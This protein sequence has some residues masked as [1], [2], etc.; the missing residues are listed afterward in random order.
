[1]NSLPR[2]A[3]AIS[4]CALMG[5]ALPASAA[6]ITWNNPAG[7]SWDDPA[8]WS[9]QQ[10]PV[11]GDVA[12]IGGATAYTIDVTGNQ[13]VDD[14]D[15][16]NPNATLRI[17]GNGTLGSATLTLND[18][19]TNPGTIE[20]TSVDAGYDAWLNFNGGNLINAPGGT[21]RSLEGAGGNRY[22]YC[23]LDNRGAL[24][25][26][27]ELVLYDGLSGTHV[28]SG[29]VTI[30]VGTRLWI[31]GG[32]WRET[33][34][35]SLSLAANALLELS[36]DFT[37][38]GGAITGSGTLKL[39]SVLNLDSDL[40]V[41]TFALDAASLT[42]NGP[43]KLVL[44]AGPE[45]VLRGWTVNAVLEHDRDLRIEGSV[46][47]NSAFGVTASRAVRLVGN[48]TWGTSSLTVAN[49]FTNLG[50]IELTTVDAGYEAWL[51]VNAGTLINAPSGAIRALAGAGGNRYLYCHLDNRGALEV[52]R[53]LVLYD[54]LSGT[55]VNSG[56]VTV[57]A[58]TRLWVNGGSWLQEASGTLDL[59]ANSLLELSG[60]FTYQGG[61]ITGAGSLKLGATLNLDVDL[62]VTTFGLEAASLTV[63]GPGKLVLGAGPEFVLRG[64]VINA[65][66]EHDRDLRIVGSVTINSAFGVSAGRAVRLAGDSTWGTSFLTVANGFTN[67]GTIE[68]TTVDAGY[69]AW[70]TVN[71]GTLVNAPSG[72]IRVLA[73]AG[74]NRYLYCHLDNRGALEVDRELSL[75][76]GLSGTHINSGDVTIAANTR[77]LVNGGSWLHEA[78]GTLDLAAN[79]LLELFGNL[80]FQGGAITGTGT[81]KLGTT[82]NLD[83]DLTVTTFGLEAS[84][85]TVNGPGK[86]VL[87]AGPE[88]VLRG[89]TVNAV[90][91]HD[92]DLR[93]EGSVTI[94]S[95]F[96][97]TASRAVRLVGNS[98]W[99]TS[100]LTVANGFTNLG[101]IEL[102]TVDAGYEAW[103]TVNAGTLVNAPSGTIRSLEGA[104][105]SRNLYCLLDN[106]GL[107]DIQRDLTL[108]DATAGPK[109]NS[110][111]IRVLAGA[112]LVCSNGTLE[113]QTAGLL[114]GSGTL[115]VTGI[116]VTND[117]TVAPG[118]SP[119]ILQITG[120]YPQ[121]ADA[122]LE[123][124]IG[125]FTA[126]SGHDQL[127]ISAAANLNGTVRADLINDFF[128]RR[129]DAVTF[130]TYASR[131]GSFTT[132]ESAEPE[133]IAW[134]VAYGPT[135]AQLIVDNSAPTF[136]AIANQTVNELTQLSVT[137]VATDQDLP[138]QT[139][140]YSLDVAPPG[141]SIVAATGAI[142][143][144]PTEA[145][146]PGNY[147][148][149]VRVVDNGTP[150]LGHTTS[151]SV[152]VNEVNVAPQLVLPAAQNIA[153][154]VELVFT[155][156]GTDADLPA[157]ALTY[158]LVSGPPGATFNP[159]TREF[160]W[161]PTEAQGPG[162][163][164]ANF[165]VT[166]NNPDAVNSQQLSATGGVS[167]AV[168][169]VNLR[170]TL[171][172]I[173]NQNAS[174]ETLFTLTATATDADLPANTLTYSLDTAPTGMTIN[175]SSGQISWTPT[176]AQGPGNFN[177]TVRV[178]DNGSPALSHTT[179]FSIAVSEVNR[180]PTLTAVAN[181]VVHAGTPFS[182]QLS[183]TD[184]D[185]PANT[186]TYSLVTGPSGATV[187]PAGVVNW[188]VPASAAFTQASFTVR[189]TDNGSPA[190]TDDEDFQLTITG[191][192]A[193]LTTV[194]AG[195]QLT[196]TWRSIPGEIYRLVS[197][198][199]V[200]AAQWNDIPG[201]VPATSGTA[202][203]SV[204]IGTTPGGTYFQVEQVGE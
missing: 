141:M 118:L 93:I 56:D 178:T 98:T 33:A 157:N 49:G 123:I 51:T 97:V 73:G 203:K 184:P 58:G 192:L 117:G 20:L 122:T 50:T 76:D 188:S 135:S 94:N 11:A 159:A 164:T 150:A 75:Y 101:T 182:L 12:V 108:W 175:P 1:M 195:N 137:A 176:E 177:V 166:D 28:N 25:V 113:N 146:G 155:I 90:L 16:T 202:S 22:L 104:G 21:I 82:L 79:S 38:Q 106:R 124:E 136:N 7:G 48:S 27:R 78:S 13:A 109:L 107:L 62:T 147:P 67:L 174:E 194:R 31:T 24:E 200:P 105:G 134:R 44:G 145:Q 171:G 42:V 142:T 6:T 169:E 161:T 191:T 181:D 196:I 80:T 165:R 60:D 85:L 92:R 103:L 172:T 69:D 35:A 144:T 187:S 153:E 149:T 64:W 197:S 10:V 47:I 30:A 204:T 61:A 77:L 45:F 116:S 8:N 66:L 110:G 43:G 84:S 57:A 131:S 71:A 34:T 3:S 74:G 168:S 83:V 199:T 55:H 126:G 160:R 2:F 87:G 54:G 102:T 114:S 180:A 59:A 128:P 111:E 46:T 39:A 26:D 52:D 72:A 86:L 100:S 190:L 156:S 167:I 185:L 40:T 68:L 17:T 158:E 140:T 18:G 112:T 95:A 139:L 15:F 154:Q 63:N 173:G 4:L 65:V 89:W 198:D 23:H 5:C 125:G 41:T 70:L 179:G 193:V 148:V 143:W 163:F 91:E 37:Y 201:D 130:L 170:P 96:G 36:G 121:S 81:L 127:A 129:N 152:T 29:D 138:A 19:F 162:N 115:N 186:F 88:F 189:V 99:G 132:V 151:F 32:S 119:G 120:D 9:P 183:A 133:R 14:L 53:E